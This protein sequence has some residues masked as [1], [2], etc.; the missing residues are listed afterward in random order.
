MGATLDRSNA[1]HV[2]QLNKSEMWNEAI[3]EIIHIF[4]TEDIFSSF[5]RLHNNREL[6]SFVS[7]GFIKKKKKFIALLL[8]QFHC[9][10]QTCSLQS[11]RGL[12]AFICHHSSTLL[13]SRKTF[14]T[15]GSVPVN[16]STCP[17][18]M[19]CS[20]VKG[21]RCFWMH[22]ASPFS[23]TTRCLWLCTTFRRG[24][25]PPLSRCWGNLEAEE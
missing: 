20:S 23:L 4:S 8:S 15:E 7:R 24:H 2:N 12:T 13:L 5:C 11:L 19:V 16:S 9:T 18:C 25:P 17:D 1:R 10:V 21:S 3:V 22:L 6:F 14:A